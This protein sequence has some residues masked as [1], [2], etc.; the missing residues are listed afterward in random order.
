M[1]L[2]TIEELD[3]FRKTGKNPAT[4]IKEWDIEGELKAWAKTA[5]IKA[6][7]WTTKHTWNEKR[8]KSCF[9][10]SSLDTHCD[11]RLY[12]QIAGGAENKE[13][14]NA[15]TQTIWDAGTAL[16]LVLQYYQH[17]KALYNNY[18]YMDEVSYWQNSEIAD[19]L[20]LCGSVDGSMQRTFNF[21]NS[22]NP[23]DEKDT[24]LELSCLWEYKTSN[25]TQFPKNK[26]KKP[27]II[28]TH[29]YMRTANIP[30]T[31]IL[32]Y[33]KDDSVL[34]AFPVFFDWKIWN[35]V[36]ERLRYIINCF[37]QLK[38]PERNT[39]YCS[40]CPFIEDCE[41]PRKATKHSIRGA[42]RF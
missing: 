35:P 30:L 39:S 5:A 28:Q 17:T 9:H 13:N 23:E 37:I 41:P 8:T 40:F 12:M 16:H 33:R 14:I 25:T 15:S 2:T 38:E 22:I 6:V 32:Y 3:Q 36:E 1:R 31:I 29:A 26:P 11:M 42:P 19:Q 27:A 21:Q 34:H 7:P 10:P 4:L 24:T 20:K 18:S